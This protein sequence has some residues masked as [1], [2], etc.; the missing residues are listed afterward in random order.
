MTSCA[1]SGHTG[2]VDVHVTDFLTIGL[3]VLL[4]SLLSAANALALAVLVLG[5]PKPDQRK[6]LRYG[7]LGAFAFRFMAT[8]FAA[9]MIQ[10]GWVKLIGALYLLYLPV[11]HFSGGDAEE[12]RKPKPA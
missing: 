3:L 5:L 9:Y 8:V 11:K 12:R 6:A 10:L 2:R 7:I 4:G 1:L